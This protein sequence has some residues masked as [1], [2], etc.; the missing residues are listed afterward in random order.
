MIGGG[1]QGLSAE[2]GDVSWRMT[3]EVGVFFCGFCY[4]P[5]LSAGENADVSDF[6]ME[7]VSVWCLGRFEIFL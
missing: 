3:T 6:P 1:G 7:T 2:T 5:G 4:F